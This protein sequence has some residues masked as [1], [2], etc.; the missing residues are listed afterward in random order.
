MTKPRLGVTTKAALPRKGRLFVRPLASA[1][2]AA[3]LLALLALTAAACGQ[4]GASTGLTGSVEIAGSST[5]FPISEAV[6]EE[7]GLVESK[8]RVSVG[9]TGTGGGFQRFC[10][11]ET[12]INDASRPI[13]DSEEEACA[14]AGV[15]WLE[16]R[17]AFDGLS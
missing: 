13:D 8:V 1:T 7:F 5:V 16:L 4:R 10:A 14:A 2:L 12:D 9:A 11:G 17:V 6:A 15:E 3:G